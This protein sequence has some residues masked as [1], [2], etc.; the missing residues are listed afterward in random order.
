M[1]PSIDFPQVT[2]PEYMYKY[3]D[4]WSDRIGLQCCDTDR[5]YTYNELAVRTKAFAANLKNK[6]D[7]QDGDAVCTI[8]GNIPEYSIISLGIIHANCVCTTCNPV[9]TSEE[10]Y[11]Q[12]INSDAKCIVVSNDV[13]DRVKVAVDKLPKPLPII[14][15]NPQNGSVPKGV[16]NYEDFVNPNTNLDVLSKLKK[17]SLDDTIFRPYSSGTTGLPKGVDLTHRNLVCNLEQ[18]TSSKML[19]IPS[20]GEDYPLVVPGILPFFHIYGLSVL[21]Y[22]KLI[23][24]QKVVAMPT[25]TINK[26]VDMLKKH[27]P[28][29]LHVV[30]PLVFLMSLNPNITKED[31]KNVGIV[32]SG[33]APV[34]LSDFDNLKKKLSFKE[35]CIMQG[36][37]LTETS[38]VALGFHRKLKNYNPGSIGHLLPNTEMRLVDPST[39]KDVD[40]GQLGE[41]WLRGP[42]VM[43]G[44]YKNEKATKESITEDGFFK[45]GDI[46]CVED[47]LVYIKDR[48]KELIKVK[49]FQVAPAELEQILR[50]HPDIVDCAVV[51]VPHEF[52]GESPKAFVVKRENSKISADDVADFLAK[53][54]VEYKRLSGGVEFLNAI[55][56]SAAGKILRR[57][58]RSQ[59]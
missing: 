43:K 36:Y 23:L 31:L 19:V 38:P 54:V 20:L 50:S 12:L 22:G 41:L 2:L 29:S 7:L 18:Q 1:L 45:T 37:G 46:A 56:K 26:F 25:F 44:Y 34:G 4:L 9:Y 48:I 32:L 59:K 11:K 58:L 47:G 13:Y 53:Q 33:A 30:P 42:Q 8:L 55:P 10:I 5:Q 52:F 16:H 14:V 17:P 40:D 21:L 27:Q 57:E 15:I 6:I 51:G 35:C 24:G 28:H 3:Y 39:G 49:G